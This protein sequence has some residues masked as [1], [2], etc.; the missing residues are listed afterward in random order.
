MGR[1]G[2]HTS[3]YALSFSPSRSTVPLDPPESLWRESCSPAPFD[4]QLWNSG[5]EQQR[6]NDAGKKAKTGGAANCG[7]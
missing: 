6:E 7:R 1:F 3:M 4:R 2:S 5:R